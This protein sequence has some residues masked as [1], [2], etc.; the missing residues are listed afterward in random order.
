MNS[1]FTYSLTLED[2]INYEKIKF[3]QKRS[4]GITYISCLILL[5]VGV[6]NIVVNRDFTVLC[7]AAGYI[8]LSVAAVLYES[9]LRPQKFARKYTSLDSTYFA[10]RQVVLTPQSIE[11][12]VK[13]ENGV[14][15]TGVYPLSALGAVFESNDYFQIFLTTEYY[16]IPKSA[17]PSQ[18]KM[19]V[20][21]ILRTRPNYVKIKNV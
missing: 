19:T 6:F 12:T 2:Y 9:R 15:T 17:I 14:Q 13:G 3:K 11:F 5:A 16:I 1:T 4:A 10:P 21:N 8:V 7:I 20:E 18:D